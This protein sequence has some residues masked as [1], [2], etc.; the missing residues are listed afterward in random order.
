MRP[1]SPR[2][3]NGWSGTASPSS[4]R[5]LHL[6]RCNC[7]PR[8]PRSNSPAASRRRRL[9]GR[10]WLGYSGHASASGPPRDRVHLVDEF[11]AALVTGFAL[12]LAGEASLVVLEGGVQLLVEAARIDDQARA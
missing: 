4:L 8:P 5:C 1:R 6:A 12:R 2:N 9:S 10:A 11:I 7:R 3:R